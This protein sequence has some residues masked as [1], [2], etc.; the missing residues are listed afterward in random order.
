M[1]VNAANV[2]GAERPLVMSRSKALMGSIDEP[3]L[4]NKFLFV[5]D[6]NLY[7]SL[8]Y[9]AKLCA[10]IIDKVILKL[11]YNNLCKIA[12]AYF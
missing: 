4:T 6:T 8:I 2:W 7:K 1:V 12:V 10:P 11:L 3:E 9:V 5:T